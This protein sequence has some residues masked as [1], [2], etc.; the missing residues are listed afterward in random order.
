MT[1]LRKIYL[2]Y[3]V[4]VA[5]LIIIGA[6]S[7]YGMKTTNDSYSNLLGTTV[8]VD[9]AASDFA[10]ASTQ[11][12]SS[13]RG[14]LLFPKEHDLYIG[15]VTTAQDTLTN[16]SK[17]LN[18]VA[19]NTEFAGQASSLTAKSSAIQATAKQIVDAV[20][21]N[22]NAKALALAASLVQQQSDLNDGSRA[23]SNAT[24]K[25]VEAQTAQLTAQSNRLVWLVI[26]LV[27]LS[28]LAAVGAALLV[29]RAIT[30]SL[31]KVILKLTSSSAELLAVSTQV[32]SSS[33]ETGASIVETTTT[34]REVKQTAAVATE[35]AVEM[36][37]ATDETTRITEEGSR[38]VDETI[39][40][41]ENMGEQMAVVTE[42]IVRLSDQTAAI[43]DV[44]ATVKDLAEQSNLLSVNAAIEAA[45]AGDQGKGFAVVA[46]EVKNLADQSKQAVA[47]V[48]DILT[49]IQKA[50]TAAVLATEL[51]S[52]SIDRGATQSRESG[53]AIE[54]L[55]QSVSEAAT[56]IR[57]TAAAAEQQLAG[58]DQISAAMEA[59]SEASSQNVA[60]SRQVEGE[61][62][63][64][65]E[66]AAE[67]ES[68]LDSRATVSTS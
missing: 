61:V 49:D 58:M 34:V 12:S 62:V 35:K 64:M 25:S 21:A 17:A 67:L 8:R 44:I 46:Q 33:A 18:D 32:S 31:R 36:K 26:V 37:A 40:G 57:Q 45:K 3:A 22:D 19:A 41:I 27:I 47:Q 2:G 15:R 52:K 60:G 11:L 68:L 59:I 4:V 54:A 48:R 24:T 56:L 14:L 10:T 13:Y 23:I 55:A 16:D 39:A 9:Q 6:M 43:S 63:H 20:N 42:S 7:I 65:R 28:I 53:A 29:S 38:S 51:G 5:L 1:L 30:R 50:T 66:V